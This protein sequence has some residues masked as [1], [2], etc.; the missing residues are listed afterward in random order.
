MPPCA[1]DARAVRRAASR[2]M[3]EGVDPEPDSFGLG[4]GGGRARPGSPGA[5]AGTSSVSTR[6]P[7][8]S[9]SCSGGVLKVSLRAVA[10]SCAEL[11]PDRECLEFPGEDLLPGGEAAAAA[12]APAARLLGMNCIRPTASA[13]RLIA[14][15]VEVVVSVLRVPRETKQ[16]LFGSGI[17]RRA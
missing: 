11:D 6:K 1:P 8:S 2:S 5:L 14:N 12:I 7:S 3:R 9:N 4:A 15:V 16:V 17:H 10:V 13:S